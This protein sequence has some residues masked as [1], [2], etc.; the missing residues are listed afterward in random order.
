LNGKDDVGKVVKKG[1][2][3]LVD[4]EAL[5]QARLR[6]EKK[7]LEPQWVGALEEI[8]L[9]QDRRQRLESTLEQL[10]KARGIKE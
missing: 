7:Y 10:K 6:A 8:E 2:Y 5:T 4:H 9:F 1:L 3:A